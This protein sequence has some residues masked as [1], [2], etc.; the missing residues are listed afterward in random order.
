MTEPTSLGRL[1]RRYRAAAALSQEALAERAG[2]SA[3]AVSDLER[4]LHHIPHAGTLD[5]LATALALTAAERAALLAAAHPELAADHGPP[6]V[7]AAPAPQPAANLPA[8][9]LPPTDLI[10]RAAERARAAG[11]LQSG[12]ARLLTLTGPGGVG[13]THLALALAH[14]LVPVFADGVVFVELAAVREA[15]LMPGAL[16]QALGLREQAGIPLAEQLRAFL[17]DKR[18]L[19]MLDNCEHLPDVAPLVADLL[20][21]CPRL[22]VLATSRTPLR[23]RAE[24]V[25]PL[26]PLPLVD[27]VALFRERAQAIQPDGDFPEAEVAAVCV[28]LDCLPLAIE[29]AAA[30]VRVRSV[31]ELLADLSS[32]LAL[33]RDGPRDL[34]ARQQ[35]ME[36]AIA[37]SYALLAEPQ[38]RLLRG[39]AV[40][41]SGWTLD[42]ARAVGWP[43]DF[44]A[45]SREVADTL[46]ALVDASLVQAEMPAS[47]PPRFRLLELIREFALEHLGETGEEELYRRRHAA[48]FADLAET[49]MRSR[50]GSGAGE[51]PLAQELPNFRAALEW[52]E[53]RREAELGLRLVGCARLWHIGGQMGEAVQW[54]ERMLA[55]DALARER[56]APAAPPTLRIERLYG[57]ARVLLGAGQLDRAQTLAADAL[58]L[59][60]Q[61]DDH[62]VISNAYATLGLIAQAGGDL[63]RAAAAFA[64][65]HA[66]AVLADRPG[67]M[68]LALMNL[69]ELARGQGDVARAAPLLEE[70]LAVA[71]ASGETWDVAIITTLLGHLAHQQQHYVE[72]L[73]RYRESLVLLRPFATPTYT[74]WCLEGVAA[75]LATDGSSALG[76]RLCAAASAFRARAGT[77]LPPVERDDFER[78]V[79]ACRAALGEPAFRVEWSEGGALTLDAAITEALS[80]HVVPIRPRRS[81]RSAATR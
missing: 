76:T 78:T 44:P 79:A 48:Y 3:R 17:G 20:A 53:A 55:L 16:A 11:L 81:A 47:G 42:A 45:A 34:P 28:R 63:E 60:E 6:G 13:K 32:R 67:L 71:R 37:W 2:I 23:L 64:A 65:C 38:R 41:S 59:A 80:A 43:G 31:R 46:A 5:R 27:A 21:Y 33:L 9:P 29:L 68:T 39:L 66:H 14:D 26:S 58:R 52:A 50:A 4:G 22:A 61:H 62:P 12:R 70:A 74:A 69:A 54:M 40:F 24:Q 25:L 1:L 51:P 35:T 15:R 57:L 36:G 49:V 8:V 7:L 73:A 75:V 18:M 72:A 77:P 30:Q 10:G 56:G 19:L